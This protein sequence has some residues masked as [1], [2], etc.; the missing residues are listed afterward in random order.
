M[1]ISLGIT[2]EISLRIAFFLTKDE[3]GFGVR[4]AHYTLPMLI[5]HLSGNDENTT[6]FVPVK[7]ISSGFSTAEQAIF[8]K[9]P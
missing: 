7:V 8:K 1:V 2:F 6:G 4:G 3:G 9:L 5:L